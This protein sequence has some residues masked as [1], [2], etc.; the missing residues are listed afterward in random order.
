MND[1]NK[2]GF[3]LALPKTIDSNA[4]K[5]DKNNTSMEEGFMVSGPLKSIKGHCLYIHVGQ[6][7][8]VPLIGRLHRVECANVKEFGQFRP[9][10][11]IDAKILKVTKEDK[12]TW[13]ELTRKK[14]H[15]ADGGKHKDGLDQDSL[16]LLSFDTMPQ[17]PEIDALVVEVTPSATAN[18]CPI[19]I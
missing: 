19:G 11:K 6:V 7:G 3:L 4:V 12:K 18:S 2:G 1:K 13:I 5:N 15:M 8:G 9:G 17:G 14:D 16:R 10:D